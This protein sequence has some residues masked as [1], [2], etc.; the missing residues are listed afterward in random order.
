MRSHPRNLDEA[1]RQGLTMLVNLP[2][3]S[4]RHD[5][6]YADPSAV[7]RQRDQVRD[8]VLKYKDHPALLAWCVG[9][10]VSIHTT[11]EQR[12]PLWR[13]L[14]T[15]VQLV[16]QVD[17]DHPVSTAMGDAYRR[18]E[19]AELREHAPALDFVGLN[20]YKDMLTM[21]EDV[22]KQNWTKPYVVTEFGPIG[23]WQVPKTEWRVPIEQSSSEKA[24]FYR[25]AYEHAVANRPLCLGSYTFLWWQKMEKTHTWYGL[26]LTDG[27]RTEAVDVMQEL[28]TGKPPVNRAPRIGPMKITIYSGSQ[29]A[30][31][32]LWTVLDTWDPDADP[33]TIAWDVREDKADDPRVGGDFEESVAPLPWSVI[34]QHGKEVT[35]RMPGK[36][37]NYRIFATV[38]DGK[39][40]AATANLPIKVG[41]APG[42]FPAVKPAADTSSYGRGIERTMRLLASSTPHHRKRVRIV[43]YGQSITKQAWWWPVVDDLR[44][45]FPYADIDAR[46]LALGGYSTQFLIRTTPQDIYAAQPDLVIFHVYGDDARYEQIIAGIRANTSAEILLQND[47][48]TERPGDDRRNFDFLPKL[49][50]KYGG[51]FLDQHTPW[52]EYLKEN[53]LAPKDLLRDA[54]HLNAHGEFLMAELAKRYFQPREEPGADVMTMHPVDGEL[55]WQANRLTLAF[56]G[57]RVDLL[58]APGLAGL[59]AKVLIDG[60]PPATWVHTRP[61][62][63]WGADWTAINRITFDRP[64]IEEDWRAELFDVNEDASSFRF[65]IVGSRTGPDGEGDNKTKFVSKSGRVVIEPE[66]WAIERG[67]KLTKSAMPEGYLIHWRAIPQFTAFYESPR[68]QDLAREHAVTLVQGLPHGKHKLELIAEGITAPAIAELRVYR[69]AITS[70]A[71]GGSSPR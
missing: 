34:H 33:L 5:F 38:H 66:D 32:N 14:N 20:A 16:K 65:R 64:P 68:V 54:V 29:T 49:A 37:G 52:R 42:P 17:P 8:L 10:E 23:H 70:P 35:I 36:P 18:G 46:N 31:A 53:N 4:P 26:L 7:E 45:R 67:A 61:T 59:K 30:G 19:L 24:A 25:K 3:G 43:F 2:M 55:R 28:W 39:G 40:S 56:E 69:P 9:N 27:S 47:H 63:A 58:A 51:G 11:P 71:P 50:A 48:P 22:A 13:E 62:R 1:H 41:P 6:N 60:A 44:R 57:N 12:V 15:L 21:P